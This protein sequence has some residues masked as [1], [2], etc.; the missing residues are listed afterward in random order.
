MENDILDALEDLGYAGAISDLDTLT[1]ATKEGAT[2]VAFT[3]VVQWLVQHIADLA[4]VEE[5]VHAIN[6]EAE[7]ANF[8]LEVSGF[9]REYGCGYPDL[10]EGPVNDR[11]NT[12]QKCFQLLDYLTSELA[13]VRMIAKKKPSMLQ[14]VEDQVAPQ[15]ESEVAA[16]L[17]KMLITLGFPKPPDNIT[18]FQLFSKV[19]AK[20][21]EL[22]PQYPGQVGKPLLKSRLSD[23]QWE[24]VVEINEVMTQEYRVRR[25]MLLKRL[26][27]TIQSFMWSDKAKGNQNKIAKVYQP[28]RET[29]TAKSKIGVAEIL[30]ARDD[31]T[32]IQKTS[33]GDSR[34]ECTINKILIGRV[35]DRGGRAWE[36]EPPPPEMPFFM[37]RDNAP[38]G[39]RPQSGRGGGGDFRGGGHDRG[40]GGQDRGR[41]GYDRGR[42]DRGGGRVQGG[43]GNANT[44]SYGTSWDQGGGGYGRGGR[45]GGYRGG[46]GGGYQG[47]GGG[48]QGGGGHQGGGGYQGGGYQGGGQDGSYQGGG[49]GYQ[50]GG[51]GQRGG[52]RGRGARG[53]RR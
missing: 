9:L 47:G 36:L 30:A 16:A 48:Y 29:L 37:K 23:K 5:R 52:G 17:K 10:T 13:A 43:W 28:V 15:A 3:Q 41:G 33:S 14:A 8:L 6:E 1:Q 20:V 19:E 24:A 12:S 22:M 31:L 51:G 4:K 45:G 32:R 49:G 46:G 38:Q 44:Q 39:H 21:K 35:P 34:K 27:V 42:G 40:R 26:D 18:A 7:S 53:A 25:E 50:G 11:L 2:S